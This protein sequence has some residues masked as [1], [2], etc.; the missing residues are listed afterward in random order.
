MT[1]P[2]VRLGQ[3]QKLECMCYTTGRT[4]VWAKGP[5]PRM[6]EQSPFGVPTVLFCPMYLLLPMA[7]FDFFGYIWGHFKRLKIFFNKKLFLAMASANTNSAHWPRSGSFGPALLWATADTWDK[8][9]STVPFWRPIGPNLSF[10]DQG[11]Q[12]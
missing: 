6:P 9:V 3:P 8:I 5:N 4:W 12:E 10:Y 11:K 7:K 1:L 2:W